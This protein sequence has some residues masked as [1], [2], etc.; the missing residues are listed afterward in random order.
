M[1]V[2]RGGEVP[3]VN[4]QFLPDAPSSLSFAYRARSNRSFCNL[5][6]VLSYS[7]PLNDRPPASSGVGGFCSVDSHR[8]CRPAKHRRRGAVEDLGRPESTARG[9]VHFDSD[10]VSS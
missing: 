6:D 4:D 5:V 10:I 2:E 3:K 8:I 9:R 7:C 1:G